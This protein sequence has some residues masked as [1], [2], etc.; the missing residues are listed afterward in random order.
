MKAAK[1]AKAVGA[2]RASV[3]RWPQ[4]YGDHGQEALKAKPHPGRPGRL[5][6]KQGERL[7]KLLLQGARKHGYNTELWTLKRVAEVIAVNFG[8]EYD[9]GHVWYVLRSVA[10]R[11]RERPEQTVMPSP[12]WPHPPS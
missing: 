8:V 2:S 11:Q 12:R 10:M 1:V 6:A 3:T 4:A 9:P 5:T 7:A